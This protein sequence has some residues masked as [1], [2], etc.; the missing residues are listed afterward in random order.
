M[1]FNIWKFVAFLSRY[2]FLVT[3]CLFCK[4]TKFNIW[5]KSP[6][7]AEGTKPWDVSSILYMVMHVRST[8]SWKKKRERER[9]S[10]WK[11]GHISYQGSKRHL[12]S[13]PQR[14]PATWNASC[15]RNEDGTGVSWLSALACPVATWDPGLPAQLLERDQVIWSQDKGASS[16]WTQPSREILA[17]RKIET[18]SLFWNV[19][20][21]S[22]SRVEM[23][24]CTLP[25]SEQRPMNFQVSLRIW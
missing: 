5:E 7:S 22:E 14:T 10:L 23:C 1:C 13:I 4:N 25:K 3:A 18:T 24:V 20:G 8:V 15:H 19:R 16:E 21:L 6:F 2:L 12:V 11:K 9:R 17:S